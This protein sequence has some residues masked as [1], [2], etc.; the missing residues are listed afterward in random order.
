MG[1][2]EDKKEFAEHKNIHLNPCISLVYSPVL[3]FSPKSYISQNV[4]FT[5][6]KPKTSQHSWKT[7]NIDMVCH[8]VV[9]LSDVKQAIRV[10]VCRTEARI[11]QC[12]WAPPNCQQL[13]REGG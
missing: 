1:K 9:V 12:V 4:P 7:I 10:I 2:T 6:N 8:I 3:S 13:A 11:T 5:E